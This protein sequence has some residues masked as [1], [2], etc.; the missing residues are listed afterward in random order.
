MVDI[1]W[2]Y[3]HR[4]LPPM[5]IFYN[6]ARYSFLGVMLFPDNLVL[7]RKFVARLLINRG[8]VQDAVDEGIQIDP[9]YMTA[10]LNDVADGQPDNKLIRRRFYWASA[11][12]QI[13]KALLALI[14]DPDPRVRQAATWKEAIEQAERRRRELGIIG[15]PRRGWAARK[16]RSSFH[17]QLKC[18]RRS[19][20]MCCAWE[21]MDEGYRPT[22][23]PEALML[24][25]MLV[26]EQ[27]Y[28]W[29]AGRR[30]SGSRNSYL[31]AGSFWR[32]PGMRFDSAHGA[33]VLAL[34]FE[35]L[36]RGSPG[37]PRK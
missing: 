19:L 2:P 36:T 33:P 23:S 27:L 18:F 37:R 20:H 13:V 24:N 31:D 11:C 35:R 26:Y 17:A 16:A 14:N 25:S 15:R 10:I 4:D 28:R 21:L 8:S 1:P 6:N 34:G 7:A 29:N 12:G 3:V 5:P 30:V 32:W 9:R 22:H